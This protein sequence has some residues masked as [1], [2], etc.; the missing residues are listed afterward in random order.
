MCSYSSVNSHTSTRFALVVLGAIALALLFAWYVK[1]DLEL[2]WLVAMPAIVGVSVASAFVASLFLPAGFPR[3]A[4]ALAVFPFG[5]LIAWLAASTPN[6]WP[7]APDPVLMGR[8][9]ELA[10]D[11]PRLETIAREALAMPVEVGAGVADSVAGLRMKVSESFRIEQRPAEVWV[12]VSF[13]VGPRQM[14]RLRLDSVGPPVPELPIRDP[15]SLT[16]RPNAILRR[17]ADVPLVEVGGP[18]PFAPA[19]LIPLRLMRGEE[20]WDVVLVRVVSGDEPLAETGRW[21]HADLVSR[22][23]VTLRG[24]GEV[25]TRIGTYYRP[26]ANRVLFFQEPRFEFQA[27]LARGGYAHLRIELEGDSLA[28]QVVSIRR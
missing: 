18:G 7:V 24:R 2:G 16:I 23:T 14:L 17:Y 9:R 19:A 6:A 21:T 11:R 5:A 28:F 3:V 10:A 13:D 27:R 1:G 22:F 20:D 25:P 8:A 4:A 15:M 12:V 26:A